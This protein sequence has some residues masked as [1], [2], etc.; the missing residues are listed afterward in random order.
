[1]ASDEE[2]ERFQSFTRGESEPVFVEA[3]YHTVSC[4]YVVYWVDILDAFLI[5]GSMVVMKEKR[6]VSRAKYKSG[7]IIDPRCI[8]YRHGV[9]LE[10]VSNVSPQGVQ[11]SCSPLPIPAT[12]DVDMNRDPTSCQSRPAGSASSHLDFETTHASHANA[13]SIPSGGSSYL[14]SPPYTKTDLERQQF[15][16]PG[17]LPT[18]IFTPHSGSS[19]NTY[20]QQQWTTSTAGGLDSGRRTTVSTSSESTSYF[21]HYRPNIPSP[22]SS[23]AS[24]ISDGI[25]SVAFSKASCHTHRQHP[26][27]DHNDPYFSGFDNDFTS[28]AGPHTSTTAIS[29]EVIRVGCP[30]SSTRSSQFLQRMQSTVQSFEDYIR[31]SQLIQAT[32]VQQEA[33]S[34]KNEMAHYHSSLQTEIAKNTTLQNQVKDMMAASEKMTKRILELQE[35]QL[36][37]DKM[38]LLLQQQALD[39]LAL[40]QSKATAIL[41]QTYE[42]HEFPI[43]R[44]FI[45]LPKEDISKREKIS[46]MF[47]KRF[48]LYFLCECGEHTRP[49]DGPP[50]SLSHDIHLARHE[51]YDLDRPNEFFRKYGSYV[52]AL[53]QALKYGVAAAGMVVPPLIAMKIAD[54]LAVAEAGL[55]MFEKDFA[56]R[57]DA[58]I[59][60]LQGLTDTQESVSKDLGNSSSTATWVDPVSIGRLEGLEGADL[61][62]LGSFLKE[63]DEGKVLGNLYRMVTPKGHVKWVCLDHYRE[64]YGA[65]ALQE[66]KEM[67]EL[68]GGKYDQK[69]GRV[70]MRLESADQAKNLYTMLLSTRLVHELELTLAWSASSEDLR[71]LKE[72][73]QLS[74]VFHLGLN[75]CDNAFPTSKFYRS[76]RA[77]TILQIMASGKIH[78]VSLMNTIGFLSQTK[79]PLNTTLH[80]RRFDLGEMVVQADDFV[81]LGK[82]IFASSMLKRLGV[83]VGDMD[84]A[85]VK[86][87]PL[88]KKHKTLSIL[89]LQLQDGTAASVQFEPGSEKIR[90]I[91]LKVVEPRAI[92]LMKMPMVTSVA[93]LTKNTLSRSAGLVKSAIEEHAVLK[94]I[95]VVQL[96]DGVAVELQELQQALD[97]YTPESQTNKVL[98]DSEFFIEEKVTTVAAMSPDDT[99]LGTGFAELHSIHKQSYFREMA[100]LIASVDEAADETPADTATAPATFNHNLSSTIIARRRAGSLVAV[101]FE[102]TNSDPKSLVLHLEDFKVPEIFQHKSP[103]TLSIIGGEGVGRFKELTKDATV[104]FSN[105]RKLEISCAP[106]G[107]LSTLQFFHQTATRQYPTLTQL[108]IWHTNTTMK[109]FVLPLQDLDLHD[110]HLSVQDFPSLQ[111]LLHAASTLSRLK[112]SVSS[113][114]QAFKIVNDTSVL[115]KQL[116]TVLLTMGQSRLLAQFTVGSGVIDSITLRN[117]EKELNQFLKYPKVTE[118][119][120]GLVIELP[121]IQEVATLVFQH[122]RYLKTFKMDCRTGYLLQ[123]VATLSQAAGAEL[124]VGCRLVLGEVAMDPPRREEREFTLPLKTLSIASHEIDEKD[125]DVIERLI[126]A[127]PG[128][129]KLYMSVSS[130]DVAQ[131]IFDCTVQ[132]SRPITALSMRLPDDAMAEFSLEAEEEGSALTVTQKITQPELDTTF[133]LPSANLQRVDVVGEHIEKAHASEIAGFVLR[134]CCGVVSIR[135]VDLPGEANDIAII[136]KDSIQRGLFLQDIERRKGLTAGTDKWKVMNAATKGAELAVYSVH[137]NDILDELSSQG[138][139]DKI[140]A[141]VIV[142]A[143]QDGTMEAIELGC[144]DPHGVVLRVNAV[145]FENSNFAQHPDVTRLVVDVRHGSTFIDDLA[146]TPI[147]TFKGL[148]Q[149]EISC[150]LSLDLDAL[151]AVFEAA[152]NHPALDQ[153]RIWCPDQAYNRITFD[154]PIK[155]LDLSWYSLPPTEHRLLQ[156]IAAT[157]PFLTELSVKV[158]DLLP[159]F[160][161][162]CSNVKSLGALEKLHLHDEVGSMLSIQFNPAAR[163]MVSAMLSSMDIQ[164]SILSLDVPVLKMLE[165]KDSTLDLFRTIQ[166]ATVNNPGLKSLDLKAWMSNSQHTLEI[167]FR[168]MDLGKR[169]IPLVRVKALKRL[170]LACPQL[171]ELCLPLDSVAD[172][173]EVVTIFGPVFQ[174]Y[175][176][177]A[178]V[179]FAL[180]NGTEASV[181]YSGEDG[182]VASIAL[183]MSAEFAVTLRPLP[184]VK[185]ITVRPRDTSLWRDASDINK[186]LAKILAVYKDLET[187]EFDC[188]VTSP[189]TA[190]F[191]LQSIVMKQSQIQASPHL[192]RYRHRTYDFSPALIT[193]DLPLVKLDLGDYFVSIGEFSV[194]SD[195]VLACPKLIDLR[196]SFPTSEAIDTVYTRLSNGTAAFGRLTNLTLKSWDGY[197]IALQW[198]GLALQEVKITQSGVASRRNVESAELQVSGTEWPPYFE[199]FMTS[200]SKLTVLPKTSDEFNAVID[201]SDSIG[202][203]LS[204]ASHK[205]RDVKHIVLT[206]PVYRFHE[207][208]SKTLSI[209]TAANKIDLH[210]PADISKKIL[211]GKFGPSSPAPVDAGRL[212]TVHLENITDEGF[213]DTFG[214]FFEEYSLRVEIVDWRQPLGGGVKERS[215]VKVTMGRMDGLAGQKFKYIVL[216]TTKVSARRVFELLGKLYHLST[217]VGEYAHQTAMAEVATMKPSCRVVWKTLGVTKAEMSVPEG[218]HWRP[219][220][221]PDKVL[222]DSEVARLLTKLLVRKATEID[223]EYEAMVALIPFIKD[224]IRLGGKGGTRVIGAERENEPFIS[225]RRYDIKTVWEPVKEEIL[226]AFGAMIPRAVEYKVHDLVVASLLS[227]RGA[228]Y[229]R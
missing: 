199:R 206:C 52:L 167:P 195:L 168:K 228:I 171:T 178:D 162:V 39:R 26:S 50:S 38:M 43:P 179:R 146:S 6:V 158:A 96:P 226:K 10:V 66:F 156:R 64:S 147:F 113:L 175:K 123:V 53:L 20:G 213:V 153:I 44:L 196:I 72:A 194:L 75:L 205:C 198:T 2:D 16:S 184:M 95:E 110:L 86:L 136:I 32:V 129:Q 150:L 227:K 160:E 62:H 105:L 159:A 40:I 80:F 88:V 89:D 76:R 132:E 142:R 109:L 166:A 116:S 165:F 36:D 100:L 29:T 9:V 112:L 128:L 7:R 119:D 1:M 24:Y 125:V 220:P 201:N 83:V 207:L 59:K 82:I 173:H 210:D 98:D 87:S 155:T 28:R 225:L 212:V 49:V 137:G 163:F 144:T 27:Q 217:R 185:K 92:K 208:S 141:S 78:S 48:R 224:E 42:L 33:E 55:K 203:I 4:Q 124:S 182:S 121:R 3:F 99:V 215:E 204:M 202:D 15:I 169:A 101:Q 13:K 130:V 209:I 174:K 193:H 111:N 30:P 152:P 103:S 188:G 127:N 69:T 58:A 45:I 18:P 229:V 97:G 94:V 223:V 117:R 151:L 180:Q 73:M 134:H 68:S 219:R 21:P 108:Y 190:L 138:V 214:A 54:E 93:F 71:T 186:E 170:L 161:V 102:F 139:E 11:C 51:G 189:F 74:N 60:H 177:L 218:N 148:K 106:Q 120:I 79:E 22:D 57:L 181:R 145:A 70:T 107:L 183:R 41:T 154:L 91:G 126:R 17:E 135:F 56:P 131:R 221:C 216:D 149:L 5:S 77:E 85:F 61:R 192:R 84:E 47:V 25:E 176:K 34:I 114:H 197:G 12:P 187:L 118:L 104:A 35:A 37:T 211:L 140:L 115:H 122:Y 164:D 67:V 8:K 222:Q 157:N 81:K 191:L 143:L 23:R 90:T 19:T 31:E 63:S 172:L 65:A 200:I 133:F 14:M 46:T